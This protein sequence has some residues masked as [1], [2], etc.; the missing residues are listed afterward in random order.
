MIERHAATVGLARFPVLDYDVTTANWHALERA[1]SAKSSAATEV[2]DGRSAGKIGS[3]SVTGHA[4][5]ACLNVRIDPKLLNSPQNEEGIKT[6]LTAK[7]IKPWTVFL[8][9]A[10]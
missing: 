10:A 4:D 5:K 9:K 2:A 1:R 6:G 3:E 7:L 8:R